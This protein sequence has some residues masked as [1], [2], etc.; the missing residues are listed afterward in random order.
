[1]DEQP[2]P[3]ATVS[4][5]LAT[6]MMRVRG[7]D[8]FVV[9]H[10]HGMPMLTMH[11]PGFDHNMLRPWLDPLGTVNEVIYYDQ[12]GC[13]RSHRE[14]LSRVTDRTWVEDADAVR[15]ALG[16]DRVFVFGHSYGGCLALEYALMY[17]QRVRGLIVCGAAPAFDY[18][19]AIIA[20]ANARANPEQ[21]NAIMNG[22]AAPA[23]DDAGL[24]E[25]WMRILPVYF[26]RYNPE[27]HANLPSRTEYSAAAFNQVMFHCLPAFKIL[28]RLHAIQTPTLILTGASDW[29]T[30]P[31]YGA[32]RLAAGITGASL[33]I[34]PESGHFPYIEEPDRFLSVIGNWVKTV[35]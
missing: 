10:G 13:G 19:D 21:F 2:I 35:A 30:P 4:N 9:R 3:Q 29:I 7:T 23:H 27:R 31:D 28:D 5:R 8:L 11:G 33:S 16:L 18:P 12:R 22:F 14:D 32:I 15:A 26:H 34:F 25:W 17:P 20:N 6:E 1:V 24:R